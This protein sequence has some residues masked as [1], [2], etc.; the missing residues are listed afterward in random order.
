MQQYYGDEVRIIPANGKKSRNNRVNGGNFGKKFVVLVIVVCVIALLFTAF[1]SPLP[2]DK[3]RIFTRSWYFVETYAESDYE[4]VV[5]ES[6]NAKERGGGGF[7]INDGNFIV[8]IALFS[9]KQN[10]QTVAQKNDGAKVYEVVIS[11]GVIERNEPLISA[12]NLHGEIYDNLHSSLV[13]F[14]NGKSSEALVLFTAQGW[15]DNA[16]KIQN[17]LPT[18]KYLLVNNYLIKIMSSLENLIK[19]EKHT[20]ASRVRYAL[21]EIVYERAKL[22]KLL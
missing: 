5:L 6:E 12:L 15:I 11:G 14:E 3:V 1:Y 10:A 19:D 7:V 2:S 13:D 22:S 17:D 9:V 4:K 8:T 21:C 18:D 20:L 16:K